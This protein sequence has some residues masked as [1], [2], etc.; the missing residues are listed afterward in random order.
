MTSQA[1]RAT[2]LVQRIGPYYNARFQAAATE[3]GELTVIEYRTVD[4][5]YAWDEVRESSSYG[6]LRADTSAQLIDQ[7]ECS[8]PEVLVCVGYAV[9]EIHHAMRWAAR[10]GVPMVLCS[11]STAQDEPRVWWKERIKRE[12]VRLFSSGLVA[13]TRAAD[14]LASL[15]FERARLFTAWDVVDNAYF[16]EGARRIREAN[17][18][19][20]P[21]FLTVARFVPKKNLGGLLRAYA[22]Y[23]A[24]AGDA[25]WPLVLSG[26]GELRSQL[27]AQIQAAGLSNRV[28]LPGFVQYGQLPELYAGAGAFILPSLSDQWGLVVNEAMA[29]SVPVVVSEQCGCSSDL[30]V[31]WETGF[32]FSP[33]D[34]GKLA[35]IMVRVAT[36]DDSTRRSMG[37]MAAKRVGVYSLQAFSDGL[38]WAVVEA[39]KRPSPRARVSALL[40]GLLLVVR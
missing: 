24:I 40:L 19:S 35:E 15:G 32:R 26:D 23:V 6:R 22:R 4:Q 29:A 17:K 16:A 7:L 8:Q 2:L 39:K 14:Y 25:A 13:G 12:L 34:E 9:R 5:I 37:D 31:D 28:R 1:H 10:K 30:V 20:Q 27:A 18:A 36:M 11:D 21:Y 38:W 3:Q 33:T